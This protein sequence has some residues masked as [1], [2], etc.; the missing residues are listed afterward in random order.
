VSHRDAAVRFV[1]RFAAGD[2]GGLEQLLADDLEVVG[3]YLD[4]R[5]RA[6]YLRALRSAPPAPCPARVLSVTDGADEVAIFWEYG[7]EDATLTVAQL[8]R[9]T[10]ALIRQILLVFDT[11]T[12]SK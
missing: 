1:Q 4:V 3:P 6:D 7:K 9:F 10:G 12:S 8:F 11:Q 5:S 2:I